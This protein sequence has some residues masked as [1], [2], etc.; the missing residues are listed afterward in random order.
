MRRNLYVPYGI[1]MAGYDYVS[2]VIVFIILKFAPIM[3][4]RIGKQIRCHSYR[5]K[6]KQYFVDH[7]FLLAEHQWVCRRK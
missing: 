2:V 5:S 1:G 7:G 4:S 6:R 3:T